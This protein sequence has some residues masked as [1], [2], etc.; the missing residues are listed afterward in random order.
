MSS[1]ATPR[2]RSRPRAAVS[3]LHLLPIGLVLVA[4]GL[5]A[6]ALL[7]PLASGAIAYRVT[8]TLRNQTIGLDAVSLVLVAPLALVAAWLCLRGRALGPALALGI[9]G[10]TAYMFA[11]YVLGPDYAHLPGNNER[12]FPLALALFA[13]GWMIAVMAWRAL[14]AGEL[15]LPERRARLIGRYVLPL[16]TL[17]AFGRYLPALADW[18][19]GAPSDAGYLAGPTFAWT[20]A[21]LDLGVLLPLTIAANVGILHGEP[22]APK[23]L[24]M[25]IGCFG[26]IGPAVAGMAIAMAVNDDPTSSTGLVV[27]MTVLGLAFLALAVA[28]YRPLAVRDGAVVGGGTRAPT[29]PSRRWRLAVT[30]VALP[31][32]IGAVYGGTALLRDPEDLGARQGWLDGSP[33]PDYT[34]PGAVL[35]VVIGGGLLV[36]VGCALAGTRRAP[37]IA[38]VMG[39]VLLVWGLVE[40]IT[41][42]YR[43]VPQIVMLLLFVLAPAIA[44]ILLEGA[45][46]AS[47]ETDHG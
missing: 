32:A 42:G 14:D 27:F 6:V 19:S 40:T 35:L 4:G 25:V 1:L 17:A 41:I 13:A 38:G 8:G 47:S 30:A 21:L 10:Y 12:L 44:L 43:G 18:M 2:V 3:H 36:T 28:V 23:L 33:F 24:F 39:V 31:V 37:L 45:S 29:R 26:L 7:G 5:V 16:L 11:Q 15:Q 9:G 22:W 20:I 46:G 34:I